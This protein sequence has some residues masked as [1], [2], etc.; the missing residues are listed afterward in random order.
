MYIYVVV[1]VFAW[2]CAFAD[3]LS[4]DNEQRPVQLETDPTIGVELDRMALHGRRIVI[5]EVGGAMSPT[6]PSYFAK[7]TA[8]LVRP[9]NTRPFQSIATMTSLKIIFGYVCS[10]LSTRAT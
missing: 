8:I 3:L 2:L 9:F 7:A 4:P 10:L 5:R 6:W 1:S